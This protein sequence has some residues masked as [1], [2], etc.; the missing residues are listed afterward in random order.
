MQIQ[1][2]DQS[3]LHA[4]RTCDRRDRRATGSPDAVDRIRRHRVDREA[5]L[6]RLFGHERGGDQ[7][8]HV[9]ARFRAQILGVRK[10]EEAVLSSERLNTR[11][12]LG[13]PAR[14]TSRSA[15]VRGHGEKERAIRVVERTKQPHRALGTP[16][17][18]APFVHPPVNAQPNATRRARHELPHSDRCRLGVRVGIVPALD[19][20]EVGQ[21]LR[22]A[23]GSEPVA[24]HAGEPGLPAEGQLERRPCAP[25]KYLGEIGNSRARRVGLHLEVPDNGRGRWSGGDLGKR[26][27]HRRIDRWFA[28]QIDRRMT[29]RSSE[30]S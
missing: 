22:Q 6:V 20:R 13:Q 25:R 10:R 1:L 17:R 30:G 2:R 27:G 21:V 11:R 29:H 26:R 24:N 8:R 23:V 4:G 18:V 16:H 12:E 7:F 28:N 5:V 14:D 15:I 3:G 9:V 19:E